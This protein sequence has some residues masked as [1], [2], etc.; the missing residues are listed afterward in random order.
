MS[1]TVATTSNC[2]HYILSDFEDVK[3]F[4]KISLRKSSEKNNTLIVIASGGITVEISPGL[5]GMLNLAVT[6]PDEMI[7]R[8]EGL[9]GKLNGNKSDDVAY[10]NGTV[11][12][13]TNAT[14]IESQKEVFE[15]G[16]SCK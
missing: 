1:I 11:V 15:M 7:N 2:S 9:M 5:V 12:Q 8:T 16:Q 10:R 6:L 3:F 13:V 4:K 14:S